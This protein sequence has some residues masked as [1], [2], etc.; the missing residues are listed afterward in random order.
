MDVIGELYATPWFVTLFSD[1][2]PM[3]QV[4]PLWDIFLNC[5][6]SF[7]TAFACAVVL[8]LRERLLLE[9]NQC[10]AL[11]LFSGI[12]ADAS[13]LPL[14]NCLAKAIDIYGCTPAGVLDL[15]TPSD[16]AADILDF[17]SLIPFT[18]IEDVKELGAEV[19]IIDIRD[20]STGHSI[21]KLWK[22]A[23]VIELPYSIC[24]YQVRYCCELTVPQRHMR[25]PQ[26]LQELARKYHM[27]VYSDEMDLALE[28]A[29]MLIFSHVP[30][31]SILETLSTQ[32]H[33]T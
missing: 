32:Q 3:E 30:C 23:T 1:I 20:G 22:E 27:V 33:D 2:L 28:F 11:V 31:V 17:G 10:S 4:L 26:P 14:T 24:K 25:P 19:C 21:K 6:P 29:R 9:D 16:A 12:N 18:T 5:H 7:V 15:E 13:T 8:S